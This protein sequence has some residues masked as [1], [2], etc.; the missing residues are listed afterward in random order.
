MRLHLTRIGLNICPAG[1]F[2]T[3]AFFIFICFA[4]FSLSGCSSESVETSQKMTAENLVTL[5]QK[6]DEEA[7]VNK[8]MVRFKL[9]ERE[10]LL[11][12]DVKA[13]RMRLL[14]PI[15]PQ[16][17]ANEDI[18]A[19]MMQ[20]NY[21]AVLDARYAL[22]NDIVWSVFIHPLSS[23]TQ[24]DFLSAVAQTVTAAETFGT[25]YTSGAIIFGGG[26]SHSIH[27]DLLKALEKATNPNQDI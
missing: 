1:V 16:S 25:S 22:A 12:Y 2:M 27:K 4:V 21:D 10:V 9:Q 26:D 7:S 17:I 11:V 15:A 20:A 3:R 18:L 6:F 5:I 8:N 14:A 13:D 24:K 19:R 23:L